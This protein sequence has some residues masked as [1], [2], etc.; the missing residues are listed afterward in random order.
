MRLQIREM[1]R[2]SS[3]VN[4][5]KKNNNNLKIKT[6]TDRT[7]SRRGDYGNYPAKNRSTTVHY[8]GY[9]YDYNYFTAHGN[10]HYFLLL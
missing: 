4:L 10:Y 3:L 5:K 9:G 2:N 1:G 6:K 8:P 7:N